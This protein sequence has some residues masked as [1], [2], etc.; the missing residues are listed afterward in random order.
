[1]KNK[2]IL[3]GVVA[4]IVLGLLIF[5][6]A[7][8]KG[9]KEKEVVTPQ[10]EK[11]EIANEIY[12]FSGEIKGIEGKILNVEGNIPSTDQTKGP[13]KKLVKIRVT[14]QTKIVELEFPKNISPESKESTQPKERELK[15]E[16]LKVGET[17]HLLTHENLKD[18]IVNDQEFEVFKIFII[19]K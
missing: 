10:E 7:P 4:L 11:I 19:K 5:F 15:F 2:D 1:M 3:L 16:N 8:K 18:K 17:I 6:A 12:G 9:L 14:D 13:I